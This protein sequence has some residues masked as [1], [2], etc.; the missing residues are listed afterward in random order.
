M[1]GAGG[2]L[3]LANVGAGQAF[4]AETADRLRHLGW[5]TSS[6]PVT[7]D[8]GADLVATIGGECLVVQCKDWGGPVGV[9]A[10]QEVAFARTHYQAQLAAVV[11]RNGY[12]RAA[13]E[14]AKTAGVY[15][16]GLEDLLRGASILDRSEESAR[17]REAET[18]AEQ[19]EHE[20]WASRSWREF[21]RATE[22]RQ[23][24][25]NRLAI[26]GVAMLMLAVS[27]FILSVHGYAWAVVGK[28][29]AENGVL[30]A[31][32]ML[33]AGLLLVPSGVFWRPPNEPRVPRRSALRDCPVCKL[34]LKLEVGRSGWLTCPRC[35]WRFH[36]ET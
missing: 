16:L 4:E 29:A 14:A 22:R 2:G 28:P 7:G 31:G 33:V 15:V 35:K 18:R 6:T 11:S 26:I 10:I 25:L 20:R 5:N 12:S 3:H 13:K 27:V 9:K 34:H 32:V 36:A 8:W 24:I 17:L 1:L 30:A 21:D 19:A 23:L